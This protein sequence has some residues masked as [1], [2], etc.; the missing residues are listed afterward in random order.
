MN[1]PTLIMHL[2]QAQTPAEGPPP[3]G[4][5]Q[6]LIPMALLFT[7]MYFLIIRPQQKKVKEHNQL[8]SSVKVGDRV[9]A[10]GGIYGVITSLKDKSIGLKISDQVKIE[11]DRA[12]ITSVERSKEGDSSG[13]EEKKS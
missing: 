11:V 1:T 7:M 8:V 3:G 6:M 13:E 12:S 9:V 2:A 4:L 5:M 10:A